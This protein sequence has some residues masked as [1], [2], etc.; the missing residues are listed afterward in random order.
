VIFAQYCLILIL[1]IQLH[2]IGRLIFYFIDVISK[3]WPYTNTVP[4]NPV[5]NCHKILPKI[6]KIQTCSLNNWFLELIYH[7][8]KYFIRNCFILIWFSTHSLATEYVLAGT[9]PCLKMARDKAL[10]DTVFISLLTGAWLYKLKAKLWCKIP[11]W[12]S[13]RVNAGLISSGRHN[14]SHI[15]P[16]LAQVVLLLGIACVHGKSWVLFHSSDWYYKLTQVW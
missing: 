4:S 11:D 14:A 7:L 9:R 16:T 2:T 15:G 10:N 8:L 5:L 6:P 1:P 12:K 13:T 3:R